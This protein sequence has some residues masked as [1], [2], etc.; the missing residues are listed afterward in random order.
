MEQRERTTWAGAEIDMLML[1]R[2]RYERNDVF[3]DFLVHLDLAHLP[4]HADEVLGFEDLA[5]RVNR[6]GALLAA[7]DLHLVGW[8]WIAQAD[9]EH[10]AVKLRLW[11]GEGTLVL[12]G[13]LRGHDEE[14]VGQ[15]MRDA[16]DGDLLLFHC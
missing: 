11:Q 12:D 4:L 8:R 10:E 15:A 5:E 2:R 9:V 7:E 14:R 13:V 16:V 3:L 6:M 1:A